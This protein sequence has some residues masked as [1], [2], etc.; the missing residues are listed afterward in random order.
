MDKNRNYGVS[1]DEMVL[2]LKAKKDIICKPFERKVSERLMNEKGCDPDT[3]PTQPPKDK[4]KDDFSDDDGTDPELEPTVPVKPDP[5]TDISTDETEKPD[6]EDEWNSTGPKVPGNKPGPSVSIKII[7]DQDDDSDET[8]PII[9]QS[10]ID[11]GNE[12]GGPDG[13]YEETSDD[14]IIPSE[15]EEEPEPEI[16]SE[17]IPE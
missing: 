15:E 14:E 13:P 16:T 5:I 7:V 3:F 8:T 9:D 12:F 17:P 1:P 6:Y 11:K 10:E 2:F 4:E